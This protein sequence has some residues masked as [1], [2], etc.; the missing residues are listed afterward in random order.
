MGDYPPAVPAGNRTPQERGR[1]RTTVE[2]RD[3]LSG[4]IHEYRRAA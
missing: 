3:V 4:L 2:R 1:P